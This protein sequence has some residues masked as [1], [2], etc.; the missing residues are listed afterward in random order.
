MGDKADSVNGALRHDGDASEE[1]LKRGEKRQKQAEY[2]A[3]VWELYNEGR[4]MYWRELLED[5]QRQL[6]ERPPR[7]SFNVTGLDGERRSMPWIHFEREGKITEA[8]MRF[9]TIQGIVEPAPFCAHYL[10]DGIFPVTICSMMRE[11][12]RSRNEGITTEAVTS[13]WDEYI[14][15]LAHSETWRQLE[16]TLSK[17]TF[18]RRI[19][20][21]VGFGLGEMTSIDGPCGLPEEGRGRTC[22]QHALVLSLARLLEDRTGVKVECH[23]QDPGY[24]SRCKQALAAKGIKVAEPETGF[25]LVDEATLVFSVSPN[26]P[27]RQIIADLTR[28]A[29]MIWYPVREEEKREWTRGSDGT[30]IRHSTHDGPELT[31]TAGDGQGV[32]TAAIS[33]GLEV[34][35]GA[36]GFCAEGRQ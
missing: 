15:K 35:W 7:T 20:K 10:E 19:D 25:L 34:L 2:A 32:H 12:G 28:P 6:D 18:P 36:G 8:A 1:R 3:R 14:E 33:A 30:W 4:P 23:V 27:V 26:V 9:E 13:A 22:M 24:T 31:S 11:D 17:A 29:A 16:E 21:I 5:L